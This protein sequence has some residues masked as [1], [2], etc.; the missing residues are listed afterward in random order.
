MKRWS[1]LIAACA[2]WTLSCTTE[3]ATQEPP[4][5]DARGEAGPPRDGEAEPPRDGGLDAAREAGAPLRDS[6]APIRDGEALDIITGD[7]AQW[8][9]WPGRLAYVD[10]DGDG[11]GG[12]SLGE[13]CPPPAGAVLI[14]GDCRDDNPEIH[15]D[16]SERCDGIDNDCDGE[17]D[18]HAIDAQPFYIDADGDGVGALQ[19]IVIG[20]EAPPGYATRVGDCND[21]NATVGECPEGTSCS[22]GG[23]CLEAGACVEATDCPHAMICEGGRCIPGGL[24]GGQEYAAD[25]VAPN[26]L[27]VLDRSCSMRDRVDGVRKW[28]SAVRA[29]VALTQAYEGEIRF[30]L[31][32]FPD[33][34][35][36]NCEQDAIPIPVGPGNE[37]AIRG[38]LEAALDNSD[39]NWPDGPCVTNIR[40]AVIQAGGDPS[41]RDPARRSFIMLIT[42]GRQANCGTAN[43]RDNET[44]EHLTQLSVEGINTFVVGFG[45]EVSVNDLNRFA[46]A[47]GVPR[48]ADEGEPRYYQA[49]N[50]QELVESLDVIGGVALGCE[51]VLDQIPPDLSDLHVFFDG[52]ELAR[53]VGHQG[54]W[55]YAAEGNMVV[56]Y[57]DACDQIMAQAVE[58]VAVVFG[59]TEDG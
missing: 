22:V 3:D 39:D 21:A 1:Y 50:E 15:P 6:E 40:N 26:L 33:R 7:D 41:L 36:P 43:V 2:L 35:A 29:I 28:E 11:F 38:L 58:D 49:N 44:R 12:A 17:V 14:G 18:A 4:S 32:L 13:I 37:A 57:G 53:D 23:Q 9:C 46:E 5:P 51:F 55:D 25:R 20:C 19:D 30:G 24:C 47:G 31:T 34:V 54:G 10:E 8:T 56:F 48:E 42:D 59:C 27:L 16:A 52:Q 45:G